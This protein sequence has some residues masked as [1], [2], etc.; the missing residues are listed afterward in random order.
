MEIA[1]TS[2]RSLASLGEIKGVTELILRRMGRDLMTAVREGRKIEHGPIPKLA[3]NGRRRI[4]RRSE[5]RLD[6]LKDWRRKRSA[7]LELDPGVLCPNA[8]LEA[9][10]MKPPAVAGDLEGRSE[11]KG[12]FSKAFGD[13]IAALMSGEGSES[14]SG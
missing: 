14:G 3:S 13:E 10:A 8:A 6:T 2:P 7:E 5:K 9:I 11:L 12:W 4:D 1:E